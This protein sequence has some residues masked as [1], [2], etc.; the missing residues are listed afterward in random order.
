MLGL[1]AGLQT[2]LALPFIVMGAGL[3]AGPRTLMITSR[4]RERLPSP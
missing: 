2:V 4:L 1:A 3:K